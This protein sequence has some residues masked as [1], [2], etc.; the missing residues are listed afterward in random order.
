[1]EAIYTGQ[2]KPNGISLQCTQ[3]QS[4]REMFDRAVVNMEFDVTEMSTSEHIAMNCQGTN[5]FV[6]IPVFPS[7]AFRHGFVTIN[8]DAGIH[9]AKDLAG[10]RI[11]LP[12]YTQTAAIW[13]RGFLA[14]DYGVDLSEVTWVEGA[15]PVPGPHGNPEAPP[16]QII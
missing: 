7:K 15:I 14:E 1:M 9:E 5:P 11:G 10:K 2:I 6:A 13:C 8:S 4:P 12:L 3:I 16:P